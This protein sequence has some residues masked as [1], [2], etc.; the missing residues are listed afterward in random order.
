MTEDETPTQD[1][2]P[3]AAETPTAE[4]AATEVEATEVEATDAPPA[5][6]EQP[7]A[8]PPTSPAPETRDRSYVKIPTWLFVVGAALILA[9][10]SFAIGRATA[11]DD[12]SGPG[13]SIEVPERRLPEIVPPDELP[14]N[15]NTAFLGVA[16]GAADDGA[17]VQQVAPGSP[18]EDAG[19]EVGDV[20]T[21][22][23]DD[24]VDGPEAL[25]AAIGGYEP[26]D[27]VAISYQRNGNDREVDIELADRSEAESPSPSPN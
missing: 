16:T 23:D 10:G 24:E 20:I 13:V 4:V 8:A 6:P 18:A 9:A 5:P 19:L 22:V 25:L 3:T 17:E 7:P 26:G 27:E 14:R 2:T 21:A 11:P 1:D 15:T 12:D